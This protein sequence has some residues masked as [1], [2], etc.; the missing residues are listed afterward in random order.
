MLKFAGE[1]GMGAAARSR[2]AAGWQPP[3]PAA[4]KWR[5]LLA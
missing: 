3:E 4:D 5:G 2:I 1:F